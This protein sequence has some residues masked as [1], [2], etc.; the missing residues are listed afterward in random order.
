MF[1]YKGLPNK[2]AVLLLECR[3]RLLH[4]QY[5][6]VLAIC[7]LFTLLLI[8][9]SI[10]ASNNVNFAV[11]E[12]T[13]LIWKD[14][15]EIYASNGLTGKIDYSG[16][17]ATAVIN[18][19]IDAAFSNGGGLVFVKS[20]NYS[21]ESSIVLKSYVTLEGEG[22]GEQS[23]ATVLTIK[24]GSNF[25]GVTT[26][27]QKNYHMTVRNL[28][29][30]GS[31]AGELD[32]S[33]GIH[34]FATDRPV[35]ENVVIRNCDD[36]GIHVE[37][38]GVEVSIQPFIRGVYVYSC[39]NEGIQISATDS[40]VSDVDVGGCGQ[41]ALY[42]YLAHNSIITHSSF[43]GSKH[44]IEIDQ[45][46]NCAITNCRV[47]YNMEDGIYMTASSYNLISSCEIY[48]NSQMS[49]GRCDGIY[50]VGSANY[51]SNNNIVTGNFVGEEKGSI[52]IYHRYSINEDGL[53]CDNNLFAK[54]DVAGCV[55]KEKIRIN[56]ASSE[57][58]ENI[59]YVTENSGTA[60]GT[61]PILVAH[62]L[63]ESPTSVT[64]GVEGTTPCQTSWSNFNSTHIAIYHDPGDG[65]A[66]TVTWYAE[67][68]P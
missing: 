36:K 59:G 67:Y 37:G 18:S 23:A 22:W 1:T 29:I 3:M 40:H 28:R 47:D 14:D 66:I 21:L 10:L 41:S 20:G 7:I 16:T 45:T 54:N 61:S 62:G 5:L 26:L 39:G 50:L 63:C 53:Y 46:N 56:G 43:W 11:S 9:Y 8:N 33:D 57:A 55:F 25:D 68:R 24:S 51:P 65:V 64:L 44:G 19:A 34:I 27:K 13:Y 58:R 38:Y 17:D 30:E 15:L 2:L 6:A 32:A 49:A 31:K 35:V 48:H 12:A 4:L 60:Y 52:T 42:M